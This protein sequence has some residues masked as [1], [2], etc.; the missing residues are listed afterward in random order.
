MILCLDKDITVETVEAIIADRT[1]GVMLFADACFNNNSD[2][3]NTDLVLEKA[4]I[5]F[6]WI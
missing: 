4:G 2:L 5:E 6:R 1:P 3:T